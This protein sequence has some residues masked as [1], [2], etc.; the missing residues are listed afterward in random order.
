MDSWEDV[1]RSLNVYYKAMNV[2]WN[3][4]KSYNIVA[5]FDEMSIKEIRA[6]IKKRIIE[7]YDSK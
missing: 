4:N 7:D 2:I 5:D 6:F 1:I 3:K